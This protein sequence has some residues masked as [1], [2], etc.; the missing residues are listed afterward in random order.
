LLKGCFEAAAVL[1]LDTRPIEQSQVAFHVGAKVT[2]P[3][4]DYDLVRNWSSAIDSPEEFA[5]HVRTQAEVPIGSIHVRDMTGAK[6]AI[7]RNIQISDEVQLGRH[8]TRAALLER[9]CDAVESK[10]LC[11][12]PEIGQSIGLVSKPEKVRVAT[13]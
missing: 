2:N 9:A 7:P 5:G 4:C 1:Q 8:E 13:G 12:D 11:E 10:K 6:S 3:L